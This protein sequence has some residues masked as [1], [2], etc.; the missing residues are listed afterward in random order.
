[1][2]SSA[3]GIVPLFW[4]LAATLFGGAWFARHRIRRS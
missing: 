4:I 2:L 3:P 1:V